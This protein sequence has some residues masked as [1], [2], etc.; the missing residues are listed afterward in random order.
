MLFGVLWVKRGPAQTRICER[1]VATGAS[2][3]HALKRDWPGEFQFESKRFC[4]QTAS[5]SGFVLG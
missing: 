5:G 1:L 3:R 4:V 2:F